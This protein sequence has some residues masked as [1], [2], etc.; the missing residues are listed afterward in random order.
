MDFWKDDYTQNTKSS[1][2]QRSLKDEIKERIRQDYEKSF[3]NFISETESVYQQKISV[4]THKKDEALCKI[5]N[6][7]KAL[8]Y[9]KK[10]Y[11]SF[12]DFYRK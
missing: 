1:S 11:G 5:N 4:L 3:E 9:E 8:E 12:E 7:I 2:K 6:E 10:K